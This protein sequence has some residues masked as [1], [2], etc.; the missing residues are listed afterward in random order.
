MMLP[1]VALAGLVAFQYFAPPKA[2]TEEPAA[3]Q[4]AGQTPTQ[5]PE[6]SKDTGGTALS[7]ERTAG[8]ALS[9]E[10]T[11]GTAL[12]GERTAGRPPTRVRGYSHS[13]FTSS[14]TIASSRRL[15]T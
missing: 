7:G 13:A 2:Q 14:R 3:E 6:L 1:L 4:A 5:A 10:R 8:T 15:P 12:S 9:G 11:A